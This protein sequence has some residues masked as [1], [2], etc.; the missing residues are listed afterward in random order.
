MLEYCSSGFP[1][2][3][4]HGYSGYLLLPVAY[5]SLS[6]P[7]SA[8]DAKAFPLRSFQ[9]DLSNH[10]LIL[11]VELCRQFNRIF[12]IVIVTHLYDVPQLKLKIRSFKLLLKR[13]LCCLAYHFIHYI[14]QFSRFDLPTAFAARSEDLSLCQVFRSNNNCCL[15]GPS[16]LEPP[17]LRLSVVR[18]SQ[19]SYGPVRRH[20]L[21][22][23]RRTVYSTSRSFRCVS[24]S[25]QTR[26]AGLCSDFGRLAI[27][28]MVEIVGIEPA[29]SCLQGRR[30]PS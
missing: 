22:I 29:T 25:S 13:P 19:L 6:R 9:L 3:E 10:L 17:T 7:S 28:Q 4:I 20:M 30:S 26:F 11:K 18:S 2:S 5:R 23:P 14:V 8:P 15:V 21:H 12:E 24:S 27:I 16:G 1:H